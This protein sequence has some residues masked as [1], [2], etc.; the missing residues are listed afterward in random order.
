M[1]YLLCLA[2]A[3]ACVLYSWWNWN[4]GDEAVH[5]DDVRWAKEEDQ[6]EDKL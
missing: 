6:F 3:L 5:A 1:A 2:S 4:R